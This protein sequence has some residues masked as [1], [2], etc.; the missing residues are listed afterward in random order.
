M[1]LVRTFQKAFENKVK[2]GWDCI[3]VFV[4][5][6]DTVLLGNYSNTELPTTF[7]PSAKECLQFLSYLNDVK[8]VMYTCSHPKEITQYVEFFTENDITFDYINENPEVKT[9]TDSLG[10][11][12]K[13]PYVNV[14]LD[15]KA[16]FDGNEDWADIYDY[17]STL[18]WDRTNKLY[19]KYID[20]PLANQVNRQSIIYNRE[21]VNFMGMSITHPHPHKHFTLLEFE[22]K[23]NDDK[24]FRD[25]FNAKL[26][27]KNE[28]I[29]A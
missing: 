19:A 20:M 24:E 6:H 8:L 13:K 17:L 11:Y 10:C 4:D 28:N 26:N 7:F 27:E 5:L 23:M 18:Y 3:Y 22:I 15:D 2:R 29:S 16:G 14:L 9:L 1:N 21:W 25:F 12:D